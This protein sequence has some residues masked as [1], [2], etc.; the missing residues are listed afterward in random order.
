MSTR[1]WIA[2]RYVPSALDKD[3]A[4][5]I[6]IVEFRDMMIHQSLPSSATTSSCVICLTPF[7]GT[8]KLKVLPPCQHSFHCACIDPWFDTN[9]TCPICR[10]EVMPLQ[11]AD[12]CDGG[13]FTSLQKQLLH[14]ALVEIVIN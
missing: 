14:M 3:T 13:A 9:S 5:N 4:Q 10:S 6:P 11:P 12:H 1:E 7:Q 2:Q 8:E